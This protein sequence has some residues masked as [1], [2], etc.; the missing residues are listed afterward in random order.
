MEVRGEGGVKG[1]N[2]WDAEWMSHMDARIFQNVEDIWMER[3]IG[4]KPRF[5]SEP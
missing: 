5:Q 2:R 1:A 3:E 4:W